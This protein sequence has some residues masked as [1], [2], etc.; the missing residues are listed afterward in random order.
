MFEGKVEQWITY[1]MVNGVAACWTEFVE[2]EASTLV[3][4]I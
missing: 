4:L 1:R 2:C 3:V